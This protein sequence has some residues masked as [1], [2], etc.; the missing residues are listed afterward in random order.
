MYLVHAHVRPPDEGSELPPD[1]R[2]LLHGYARPEDGLEH[3]SVHADAPAG[4]VLGL[5]LLA[6]SLAGAEATATALCTRLLAGDRAFAHW[7]LLRAEAPLM[8]L[9]G[10]WEPT[11]PWGPTG[12]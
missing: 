7:T 5:Y 3:V 8:R 11:G 9:D 4:P 1:L 10:P 6:D 12:P 2:T